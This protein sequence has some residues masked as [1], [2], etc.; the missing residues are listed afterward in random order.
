MGC[1]L[2]PL[3]FRISFANT[4]ALTTFPLWNGQAMVRAYFGAKKIDFTMAKYSP[5]HFILKG[6]A[7]A[8]F[9]RSTSQQSGGRFAFSF[10]RGPLIPFF[11][12]VFS[13]NICD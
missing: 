13:A 11:C 5:R 12:N 9:M 8:L 6:D 2:G 7:E 3:S 1:L 10:S 4:L